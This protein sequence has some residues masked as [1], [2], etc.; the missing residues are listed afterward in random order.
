[1]FAQCLPC[2]VRVRVDT[3]AAVGQETHLIPAHRELT[4]WCT[5]KGEQ[6]EKWP[7]LSVRKQVQWQR[8]CSVLCLEASLQPCGL[9]FAVHHLECLYF[10]D[11]ASTA[12]AAWQSLPSTPFLLLIS[13]FCLENFSSNP[14]TSKNLPQNDAPL[15]FFFFNL[16]LFIYFC[17]FH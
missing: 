2:M 17:V 3:G 11:F 1:M 9:L 10:L 5:C 12:A 15:F 16:N 13:C 4:V 8:P 14:A 6:E 7:L